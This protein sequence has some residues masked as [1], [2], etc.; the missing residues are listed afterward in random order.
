MAIRMTDAEF[1][2]LASLGDVDGVTIAAMKKSGRKRNRTL[3]N[4]F[5]TLWKHCGGVDANWQTDYKFDL[6]DSGME[7]D[8]AIPDLKIGI[9][10]DGGQSMKKG[11]HSNW[12]GVHRDAVKTNRCIILGW[13]LFRLT[14]S[15]MSPEFIKPIVEY[16]NGKV[17]E[18]EKYVEGDDLS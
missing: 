6:P 3:E 16:I 17:K 15:T 7:I 10:I 1:E 13:T 5:D 12:N 9:E 11:G 14:T 18:R 4:K 2:R 8:R